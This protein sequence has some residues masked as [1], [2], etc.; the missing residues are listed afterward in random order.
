[1]LVSSD[2]ARRY[3]A[4]FFSRYLRRHDFAAYITT[5]LAADFACALAQH[6]AA[7]Q[8]GEP[9]PAGD[10]WSLLGYAYASRQATTCAGCGERKHTPLRIDAMG[11]YVC[12][13]C[14]DQKLGSLLGEF[15]Y[16]SLATCTNCDGSG[17]IGYTSG[18]TPEQF[19]QGAYPCPQCNDPQPAVAAPAHD[20]EQFRKPVE[21]WKLFSELGVDIESMPM[22]FQKSPEKYAADVV[23]ADRLL[24]LI[25]PRR[26]AAPGPHISQ[27]V[28]DPSG[29]RNA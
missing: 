26:A 13:T 19:E 22:H 21:R 16:S 29:V 1:M 3:V 14:I 12:L 23:E 11:G 18:Q 8:P 5:E 27:G 20:L 6:L 7:I 17:M 25:G 4:D 10:D 9:A 2:V 24:A 28:H 15:G